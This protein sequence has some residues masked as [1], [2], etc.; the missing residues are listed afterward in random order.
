MFAQFPVMSDHLT[1]YTPVAIRVYN[2]HIRWGNDS[3]EV[4]LRNTTPLKDPGMYRPFPPSHLR[5]VTSTRT[6]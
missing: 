6:L 1:N 5:S 3:A 4:E 2:T